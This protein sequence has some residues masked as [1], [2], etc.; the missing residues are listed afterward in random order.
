LRGVIRR[1]LYFSRRAASTP[2]RPGI[3]TSI[4]GRTEG[5]SVPEADRE[6]LGPDGAL[7]RQAMNG[8][9]DHAFVLLDSSYCVQFWSTGAA[10]MFGRSPAD[11]LGLHLD[12]VFGE[13]S[14]CW[15]LPN[16]QSEGR[17]ADVPVSRWC[18]F[19][20]PDGSQRDLV[21]AA[22]QLRDNSACIGF[23]LHALDLAPD[24]VA[25]E[26]SPETSR[27]AAERVSALS[28]QLSAMAA[29][30]EAETAKREEG[31][32]SRVRQLRGI[33]A[34][35]EN[36]RGRMARDLREHLGQQLTALQLTVEALEAGAADQPQRFEQI[37]KTLEM[38]AGIGRGLDAVAWELRPAALDEFGLSAVLRDYVQQWSRHAGIRSS[39]HSGPHHN[40]R[41]LPEVEATLY[42]IARTALETAA[43]AGANSVDVL[44][45][46]RDANALLV[47]EDDTVAASAS[48]DA[49]G[50][51]QMRERAAALGGSVEI[52]T[53][54]AGGSAI[55]A[56][57][58]LLRSS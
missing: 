7:L 4:D 14:R 26:A 31:D 17:A 27:L 35:Q 40:E 56:C 53:T 16:D 23:V 57:V 43:R 50:L 41:F 10:M 22:T 2:L 49:T 33:V 28:E 5:L 42:R 30:L 6:V 48:R 11:A 36:E 45:D 46:R 54:A 9:V 37:H 51:A 34:A 21:T 18:R 15:D 55:L 25:A 24:A 20:L 47:V 13:Q 29:R 32:R 8:L 58:P 38:I 3:D 44:L 1:G 19:T 12:R 39:F 52:E